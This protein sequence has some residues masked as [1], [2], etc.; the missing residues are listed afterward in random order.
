[1]LLLTS[2]VVLYTY[3]FQL[4]NSQFDKFG[5]QFNT[6]LKKKTFIW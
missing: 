1:M 4:L 2:E 5:F 6:N 3:Q